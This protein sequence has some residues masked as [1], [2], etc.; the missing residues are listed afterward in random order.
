MQM[1]ADTRSKSAELFD[2][3]LGPLRWNVLQIGFECGV[4]DAL[5][6]I[7]TEDEVADSLGFQSDKTLLLLNALSSLG[8]LDKSSAGFTL[9][10]DYAP[11]LLSDS[12]SSMRDVLLHLNRVRYS[13]VENLKEILVSG[14]ANHVSA[15]FSTPEFWDKA[16]NHLRSFHRSLSNQV[17]LSILAQLPDWAS[18]NTLLD[19][20]AGSECLATS[21]VAAKPDLTVT[22]FD[23][24]PCASRISDRINGAQNIKVVSGDYNTDSIGAGYDVVWSSMSLYF[25][26]DIDVLL[27]KIKSSLNDNGKFVSFHEGLYNAGTQPEK[28]VVG[29]LVPSL[30]GNNLSFKKRF[31][32]ERM[33]C[34]GFKKVESQTILTSF[35]EMDIDVAYA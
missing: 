21:L 2:M 4:F 31:I 20:G 11:M 19:L 8:Y 6:D 34:V 33:K 1:M 16:I 5:Q 22:I 15:N 24:K 27:K 25:A 30:N 10:D 3:A 23:L 9:N 17:S 35:G 7:Q 28:H 13:T 32:A 12:A 26:N 18:V 14:H 29:R